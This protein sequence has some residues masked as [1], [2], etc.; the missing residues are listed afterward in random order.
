MIALDEATVDGMATNTDAA[1]NGRALV[2]KKKFTK[3]HVS[4]DDQLLF[5]ECQG[6]GK[7][8]Y[9]C[10][11]DYVRPD[12]PTFR[13]SCP[14]RQLPCKHNLGLLYAYA[15]K[16]AF[17]KAAVPADLQEKRE[18]LTA[19]KEKQATAAA[20]PAKPKQVNTAALAKK[21]KAQLDGMG[22]LEKLVHDAVR[23]G[24]GNMNAKLAKQ[25][26]DQAKKL[27]DAYLPGARMALHG[28]TQLFADEGGK[29]SGKK[30]SA[31]QT[32]R[33][34]TEALDQLAR[35]HAVIKQ[36]RAYLKKRLEDPSLAVPTDTAI[37]AWLGHA[38]QLTELKACG[39]VEPDV[40]LV[41]LAFNSH[42]DPARQELVDTGIWM[43][44]GS[45]KIRVTQTLRP[46]KAL[47]FIK[48][49]DSV[50][51]VVQ[52]KD[53]CV[54]PGSVNPRV[55]WDASLTRPLEPK[56]LQTVRGHGRSDFP[57]AVKDVKNALRAPLADRTPILALNYKTF[58]RVAGEYVI[59]DAAGNRL[60]LTDVGM[61]E[62]PASLG[63]IPLLPKSVF[64]NQTMIARFRHD[65]DTR[66]LRVKPLSIV[67]DREVVR[68][69]L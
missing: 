67:T 18:K 26:E 28:Y 3:L 60:V 5:G 52:V 7:D 61:A 22:V 50:Y 2:A 49:E 25:M 65:L 32:E 54:Y 30:P 12:Q 13:C 19:R 42:D 66:Q 63:M 62:E 41:Q 38:W 33:T 64:A 69:T 14:S 21:V 23:L 24:V 4:D 56:D 37:A 27:G 53:L 48:A 15:Q 31:A 51:G 20:E 45:G 68:L 58:G 29:F 43:T 11:V 39:L 34:H 17:T 16:K 46:Y 1:K 44:L 35:L 36:G 8:P 40:E 6:S 47:K 9:K 57:A 59:E 55:R 10:S